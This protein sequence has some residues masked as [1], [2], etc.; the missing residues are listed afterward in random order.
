MSLLQDDVVSYNGQPIA[1]VVADTFER[2]TAASYAAQ[3]AAPI[4]DFG[5][6]KRTPHAPAIKGP[7][8]AEVS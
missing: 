5:I 1:V 6:A 2:A 7:T 4:L 3:Q 8:P